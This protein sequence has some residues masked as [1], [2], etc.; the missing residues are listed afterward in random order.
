[1]YDASRDIARIPLEKHM[2]L[3]EAAAEERFRVFVAGD[4]LMMHWDRG[5][6]GVKIRNR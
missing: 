1:M 4:V 2:S 3:P 6:Y 5:G